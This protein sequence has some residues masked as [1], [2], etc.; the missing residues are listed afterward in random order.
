MMIQGSHVFIVVLPVTIFVE[1]L[2][3]NGL[4]RMEKFWC[5]AMC[6]G[7]NNVSATN[8]DGRVQKTKNTVSGTFGIQK[9]NTMQP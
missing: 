6:K 2:P 3:C 4:G 8:D 9:Y 1:W 7:W 5:L